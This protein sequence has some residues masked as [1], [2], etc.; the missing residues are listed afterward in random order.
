MRVTLV[1]LAT[2]LA[3]PLHIVH[4]DA[5][6]L[7]K[8]NGAAAKSQDQTGDA[9]QST[10]AD[11]LKDAPKAPALACTGPFAKDSSHTRLT[12]E[13]GAKNVVFKDVETPGSLMVKATVVFDIDPTKRVVFFWSDEKTR[14]RPSSILIEAP[15]TWTGPGGL[16]NGLPLKELE[17]LNGEPFSMIAFGGV[18]GGT[19][20]DLKGPFS[21]IEGGCKLTATFEPG[22]ANP[23]PPRYASITG[24]QPLKSTNLVLRR[25]RPQVT[26]WRIHY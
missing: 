26:E 11:N 13:F 12:A 9:G 18:G 20:K 5:A 14:A 23:L 21:G 15:S 16:R 22:I 3:I 24:D 4:A 1:I 6:K 7:A 19:V 25:V 10:S 17:K 8:T 2:L